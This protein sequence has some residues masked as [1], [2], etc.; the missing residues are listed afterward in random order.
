MSSQFVEEEKDAE[1]KEGVKKDSD[2]FTDGLQRN[3]KGR[4]GMGKVSD[5]YFEINN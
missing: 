3:H 5:L 4:L 2:A 1:N